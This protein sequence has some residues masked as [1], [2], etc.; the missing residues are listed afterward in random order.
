MTD[1]IM[2]DL[3][4]AQIATINTHNVPVTVT[5]QSTSVLSRM[6]F[7]DWLSYSL[8]ILREIVGSVVVCARGRFLPL[9]R[10]LFRGFR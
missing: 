1:R 2:H 4:A 3:G 6:L 8:S 5:G 10:C 7:S 9:S